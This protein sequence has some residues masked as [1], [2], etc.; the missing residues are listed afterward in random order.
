MAT[1]SK[2][3]SFIELKKENSQANSNEDSSKKEITLIDIMDS[4]YKNYEV[5]CF[6]PQ[7]KKKEKLGKLGGDF[8]PT[9]TQ[10]FFSRYDFTHSSTKYRIRL[11]S[12]LIPK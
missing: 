7:T 9:Q 5:Y 6:N 4:T 10:K 11:F 2:N 8:T 12:Y 1:T 3:Q